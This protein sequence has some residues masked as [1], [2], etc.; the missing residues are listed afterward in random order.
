MGGRGYRT[1]PYRAS[2]VPEFL[3]YR[4]LLKYLCVNDNCDNQSSFKSCSGAVPNSAYSLLGGH[5]PPLGSKG[6]VKRETHNYDRTFKVDYER[7][8]YL[9]I[10]DLLKT[11]ISSFAKFRVSA[12][13]LEIENGRHKKLL[14]TESICPLCKSSVETEIHFCST[15][16]H[17]QTIEITFIKNWRK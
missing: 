3:K 5:T 10:N 9:L 13:S 12:H 8:M 4:L 14:L 1:A 7:E 17:Y 15:V 16:S 11:H 6:V 2:A